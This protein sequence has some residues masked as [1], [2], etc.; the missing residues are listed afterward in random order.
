MTKFLIQFSLIFCISILADD[1]IDANAKFSE[2]QGKVANYYLSNFQHF[3]YQRYPL[4]FLRV[5][6]VNFNLFSKFSINKI[7]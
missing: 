4:I 2:C 1:H 6:S 5:F 3:L 7:A